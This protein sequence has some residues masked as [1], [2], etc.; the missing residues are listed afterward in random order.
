M[1]FNFFFTQTSL[2]FWKE[3]NINVYIT[4]K[5]NEISNIKVFHICIAFWHSDIYFME[6]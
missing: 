4:E 3:K 1:K 6:N 5:N 2:H